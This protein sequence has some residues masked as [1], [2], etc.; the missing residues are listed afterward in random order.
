M[1][2]VRLV[3]AAS[4]SQAL[5]AVQ[6]VCTPEEPLIPTKQS[7]AHKGLLNR[8]KPDIEVVARTELSIN[9]GTL[10]ENFSAQAGMIWRTWDLEPSHQSALLK[11]VPDSVFVV[12]QKYAVAMGVDPE[13]VDSIDDI[14]PSY[15]EAVEEA[16]PV[17]ECAAARIEATTTISDT[18]G[19]AQDL[20]DA[21]RATQRI[22]QI[23]QV[24]DR[25]TVTHTYSPYHIIT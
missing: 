16:P 10:N 4:T 18:P 6:G 7:H 21:A 13:I 14:L 22:G 17:A 11:P 3:R 5:A 1:L 15:E 25:G 9:G 24:R 23:A 8:L 19:L 2:L 20:Q 12:E